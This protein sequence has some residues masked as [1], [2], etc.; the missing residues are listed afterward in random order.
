MSAHD[1]STVPGA[2]DGGAA[3]ALLELTAI[4]DNAS[5]GIFITRSSVVHRCNLRAA[6]IFGYARPEEL[7]GRPTA[8]IYPDTASFERM[9]REAGPV[10]S[11]G[12]Q[13]RADWAFRKAD[14][15]EVWCRVDGKPTDPQNP[16]AGTAW[17]IEDITA[18]RAAE[19]ALLHSKAV[20][21]D[22]LAY[23]DQGISLCDGELNL[24]AANQRF[25][26]LLDFPPELG[27]P[28]T[29]FEAFIRHNAM[30]GDYGPGDVD[31]QV[32]TR[33]EMAKRFEPHLFERTRPD[34]TVIEVRGSPVPGGRGFVTTYTDI[35][36]RAT[37]ER[38]L[39]VAKRAAEEANRS[40][41]EFLANMSHEIRTPLNA[42]IGLAHLLL[43]SELSERQRD[44]VQ[45]MRSS[46][47]HLLGI[48][49]D[50]LDFSK[51]EAGK[52]EIEASEF[53]PVTLLEGVTALLADKCAVKGLALSVEVDPALPQH[54]VGDSLRLGQVLINFANNAVKFTERGS[55]VIKVRAEPDGGPGLPVRF[56]VSDTGIGLTPQQVGRLFQS[57]QQAD[58][59][60]TRR[61]GGTGLGLAISKRLAELMGGEVGVH[62]EPGRGSTFWF[63]ARLDTVV[64][65]RAH[66][67]EAAAAAALAVPPFPAQLAA[68]RGKR[69][70]LVEDND[71]NQMVATE[72]L[73]DAGFV[74]DVAENGQAA[75][76]CVERGR[77]DLVLMDMQMPVMDGV[78]ATRE[79]RR[80]PGHGQLPVVAMTANAMTQDRQRCL[81]AGMND[82]LSKPI[83]PDQVWAVLLRWLSPEP[84]PAG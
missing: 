67:G 15:S 11:A 69:I 21:D 52:L 33:V 61:F 57:F 2:P 25:F 53:A 45:K 13:F 42:I 23:M 81:D 60:T 80:R 14:G 68:V 79:L 22:T 49:N 1:A 34:G 36:K 5:V 54:L 82:F 55:V 76:D 18:A 58:S 40:K 77:Y 27:G 72:L 3:Q 65:G 4:F 70:L 64:P 16:T 75:L 38:E 17:V 30:R 26:E 9:G 73:Q 39:A 50:V 78:T 6:E 28:G 10:L 66:D 56:E 41:S 46:G 74:V 63:T 83:E 62:S 51:V 31:E 7:I 12:R 37:A 8:V 59:S 48:I 44:Y 84:Q 32:R 43:K 71:I 47:D 29:P 35:T 19:Q 24:I 20:L